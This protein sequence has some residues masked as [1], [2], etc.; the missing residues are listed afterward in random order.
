[1]RVF[2]KMLGWRETPLGRELAGARELAET[3]RPLGMV[4]QHFHLWPHMSVL[5]NVT[6]ALRLVHVVPRTEAEGTGKPCIQY[7]GGKPSMRKP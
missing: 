5:D 2:G 7:H 6:L 3:R 1:M 4:F